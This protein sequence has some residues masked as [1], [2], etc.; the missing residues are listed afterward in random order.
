[1]RLNLKRLALLSGTCARAFAARARLTPQR[2]DLML[3]IRGEKLL[4]RQLA[5][6]LCVTRPVVSR[7]IAALC[8]L[9]LVRNVVAWFD[10]RCRVPELTES[11]QAR[12]ALCFPRPTRRGAQSTG[13]AEWL[14]AWRKHL[15]KLGIRVDSI[16]RGHMPRT[17]AVYA[18]W[19]NRHGTG[20]ELDYG[21]YL[22]LEAWWKA[23]DTLIEECLP[24]ERRAALASHSGD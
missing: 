10:R 2:V 8:E 19:N 22:S 18:A 20:L 7:M 5:E 24:P 11:G 23:R 6:R 15:A 3:L 16:L 13:E 21:P 12:L 14:R 4:Q 9:G 1:M 17:F